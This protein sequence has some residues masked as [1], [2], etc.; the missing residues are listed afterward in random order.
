MTVHSGGI[1]L[2]RRRADDHLSL[3]AG[4]TPGYFDALGIRILEGRAFEATDRAGSPNVVI[5]S[6][7]AATMNGAVEA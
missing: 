5:L 7:A 6:E 1:L 2:F 3:V 4:V